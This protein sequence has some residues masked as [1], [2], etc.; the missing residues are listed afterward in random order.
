MKITGYRDAKFNP[1]AFGSSPGARPIPKKIMTAAEKIFDDVAARGDAALYE[2]TAKLEKH[3]I[4][5]GTVKVSAQE[6]RRAYQ[7]VP[8]ED[9]KV[10]KLAAKR[11]KAYHKLQVPQ[12]F[13]Y[14]DSQGS[15]IAERVLPLERVGLCIPGGRALASTVLMTAL[16]AQLAGVKE[17]IMINPW[18]E[19]R[20]NAHVLAAAKLM[21]V[22]AVYKIGGVQGVAA[23]A[24]GTASMPRV[25]KIVGPG[26]IW[27]TA[28]KA[29]AV[30]RGLCG[31]DSLA[32][33]SEV[34]V[35]ADQSAYPG[36]VAVDLL[37]Q[38]EHGQDSVSI[39]ICTSMA[40]IQ[41]VRGELE[42]LVRGRNSAW[43]RQVLDRIS[44]VE[45]KDLDMAAELVNRIAPEHLEIIVKD[46]A[47]LVAKI[48]NAASIFI[49]PYSPV[50][51]GDYMAGGNH[52]LPTGGAARFSSPLSV[53][54][55]VK[56]QSVTELSRETLAAIVKPTARF[57]EIEGLP[58]HALAVRKRFE[59]E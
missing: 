47:G 59:H 50:P 27:V 7:A 52:V 53:R 46:P 33:P 1:A 12:G 51:V 57:A 18:P 22:S 17:I 39:L 3:R 5:A 10:I 28:A 44:A 24:C 4:T 43:P 58:A 31:I 14:C 45:V 48:R 2:W 23:L 8:V 30:A 19:G 9:L 34:A 20:G 37:S 21:G 54:D 42:R 36:C 11:I 40:L 35:V 41:K 32:G 6:L 56:R 25:D 38:A 29:I 26:S 16:P 55:F 13:R 49:G 15:V